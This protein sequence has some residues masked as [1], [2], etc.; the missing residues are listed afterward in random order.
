MSSSGIWSTSPP[1][2][3]PSDEHPA[4]P[5]LGRG[6]IGLRET[7][8]PVQLCG[9]LIS[10]A[11]APLFLWRGSGL[12]A[13][14]GL[15]SL[16][17]G[18]VALALSGLLGRELT[19]TQRTDALALP[20][21]PLGLGGR[22][23]TCAAFPLEGIPSFSLPFLAIVLWLICLTTTPCRD[24]RQSKRMECWAFPCS[25]GALRPACPQRESQHQPIARN[26]GRRGRPP[27]GPEAQSS[28]SRCLVDG[29]K[30]GQLGP[31]GPAGSRASQISIQG[32]ES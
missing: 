5:D 31:Q 14:F 3:V 13:P 9:I 29:P 2:V 25:H 20:A 12:G 1:N 18:L 23:L 15:G 28:A 22:A 7:P 8:A 19:R 16:A 30:A 6:V 17:I 21:I 26:R 11:G 4:H 10:L 24:C 27:L 32:L